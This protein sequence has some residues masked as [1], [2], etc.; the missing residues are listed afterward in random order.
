MTP[1]VTVI[2]HYAVGGSA[3]YLDEL[4]AAF[5]R[6]SFP[7]VF[8]YPGAPYHENTGRLVEPSV[9][10]ALLDRVRPL[11][12]AFH[13]GRYLYN[14]L[15]IR[16]RSISGVAHILFPFYLTDLITLRRLRKYGIP[17]VLTV[18]EVLP[19]RPYLGGRLDRRLLDA[20]YN[21]SDLLAVHTH[22]LKAS[23][24]DNF[25]V[26]EERVRVVRHAFFK[27]GEPADR[28]KARLCYHIP[29]DKTVLLFFGAIRENKGL[30]VLIEAFRYLPEKF[31]LL[32]AGT[33]AGASEPQDGTYRDVIDA[34]GL[35]NRVR[36]IN[37][38]V[39]DDEIPGIFAASDAAIL[40]YRRGFHAQSGVLNL[41]VGYE[42]HCVVSDV[43]GLGETVRDYE[44]GIVVEPEDP[45]SLKCGIM[46]LFGHRRSRSGFRKYKKAHS[47]DIV[48]EEYIRIY[49]EL[50]E[51]RSRGAVQ[52]QAHR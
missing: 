43:G 18:H 19:H 3:L 37:R 27:A 8:Q 48:A 34:A 47:W 21:E 33:A 16:P 4:R 32:I 45:V 38:Y 12:L 39:N 40:P 25:A 6:M 15:A 2:S 14:A 46:D 22:N 17:V 44:L 28:H 23:L 29:Q 35:K 5:G 31:F 9:A 1:V 52:V 30:K 51:E 13:L 11:K 36:W 42:L 24:L 49:G 50:G 7:A 41:A 20:I 10:P 26:P